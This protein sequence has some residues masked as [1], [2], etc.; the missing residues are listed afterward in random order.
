M[1]QSLDPGILRQ[2]ITPRNSIDSNNYVI[3]E[4]CLSI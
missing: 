4:K 2:S 1:S 3:A